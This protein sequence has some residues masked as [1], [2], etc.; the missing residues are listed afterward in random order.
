MKNI[1]KTKELV[2]FL[3]ITGMVG[4]C[5]I[6]EC[7]LDFGSKEI[8]LRAITAQESVALKAS[9][10]IKEVNDYETLGKLGIDSLIDIK[11][12]L[13]SYTEDTVSLTKKDNYLVLKELPSHPLSN[14][15]IS[16]DHTYYWHN[17]KAYY[18]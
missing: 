5:E 1:F 12:Y 4:N 14:E 6:K 18:F 11:K 13:D 2:R 16:K 17:I 9:Y 7:V 3:E 15:V 10:D 8:E